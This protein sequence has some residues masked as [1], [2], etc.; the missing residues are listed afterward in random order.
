MI[1]RKLVLIAVLLIAL[2]MPTALLGVVHDYGSGVKSQ[3]A[4]ESPSASASDVNNY[5]Q[6]DEQINLDINSGCVK[7]LRT[8]QKVNVNDFVTD[9]VQFKNANPRE[10]RHAF[11]VITGKE[12]GNA[13]V[14]QDKVGKE[15]Y[16][17]VVCPEFQLPYLKAA[18]EALDVPWIKVGDSGN[19]HM[20]YKAK[21]RPVQDI[22]WIS[23]Y[24]RSW[25]GFFEFDTTNNALYF[26]DEPAC[27]GL[28][29][30]ALK[31]IDI[32][33]S[34][35]LLEVAVYEVNTQNDKKI[36]LDFI[37]WKN[38]PGRNL[39]EGIFSS[40]HFKDRFK[41]VF[42]NYDISSTI[43]GDNDYRYFNLQAMAT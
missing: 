10:L 22:H 23:Q 35:V 20:Y 17:H 21:F 29:Q 2:V 26:N 33:P 13:D 14:L 41:Y 8:D 28:Q 12:G 1:V 6:Q 24:Y 34:Q 36:G 37:D 16:L 27:E 3:N 39:F 7:V 4:S 18:A 15:Y 19:L 9:L 31:Q 40:L 43:R 11:R 38:G 42:G 30:W 25:E 32:P 5:V